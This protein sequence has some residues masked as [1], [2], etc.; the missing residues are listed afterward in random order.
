MILVIT[1]KM[2]HAFL[3]EFA[4]LVH[5]IIFT[6]SVIV[7]SVMV[8]V[9]ITVRHAL[10]CPVCMVSV[11]TLVSVGSLSLHVALRDA[12]TNETN[13]TNDVRDAHDA[14]DASVIVGL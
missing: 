14:H 7:F 6:I 9:G 3:L 11:G 2:K 13:E 5:I 8:F 10:I 1:L 12:G 4:L